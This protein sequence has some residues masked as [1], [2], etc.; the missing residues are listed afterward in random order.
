[1][2][3]IRVGECS[4]CGECCGDDENGWCQ[5]LVGRPPGPTD[6]TYQGYPK[7][8]GDDGNWPYDREVQLPPHCT[9]KWISV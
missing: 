4:R 3:I 5:Y 9:Y 6:C 8:C 2:P 1:M 7:P